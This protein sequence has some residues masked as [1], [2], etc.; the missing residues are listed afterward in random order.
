MTAGQPKI[1]ILTASGKKSK[2]FSGSEF[3]F[4]KLIGEVSRLGGLCY[5][6]TPEGI[7]EK[8]AEG[9]S[10]FAEKHQWRMIKAPLPDVIYN[11]IPSRNAEIKAEEVFEDLKKRRIILFNPSFFTKW[12]I[13]T[14]LQ[15]VP[16]LRPFLPITALLESEED[17]KEYT[18]RLGQAYIKPVN[19]S[20]GKGIVKITAED[21]QNLMAETLDHPPSRMTVSELWRKLAGSPA[22]IQQAIDSD[23]LNGKKYDLR[24]LGIFNGCTHKL[25]GTGVRVSR[26]QELTTHVPAGGEAVP[27]HLIEHRVSKDQLHFII[28]TAGKALMDRYGLIG[29]FSVDAGLDLNGNLYIYEI[30]SKPMKFDEPEIESARIAALGRLFI[31][32]AETR[33]F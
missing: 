8:Y 4:K 13:W 33:S 22:I 2:T 28:E 6:L 10:F 19:Q 18:A 21:Q 1:A 17:L 14:V 15:E 24:L 5:I 31:H 9:F 26:K 16:L 27:F 11:R 12:E 23:L 29:E 20:K 32:I 25:I 30:N 3:Y 7:R